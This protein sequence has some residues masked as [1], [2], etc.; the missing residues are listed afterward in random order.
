MTLAWTTAIEALSWIE[1]R[2]LNEDAA[3]SRATYQLGVDD[4]ETVRDAREVVYGVT[5][6]LNALDHVA[7]KALE[8]N[9][10]GNL[11]LG[12]RSFLRVFTYMV[13]YGGGLK[14]AYRF[15]EHCRQ[16]LGERKLS[17]V[18][19]AVELIPRLGIEFAGLDQDQALALTYF[20]PAW[21]VRY[22]KGAFGGEDAVKMLEPVKVPKYIRLNTLRD[23]EGT[24]RSLTS[25]GYALTKDP[26]LPYVYRLVEG[27]GI[28]QT[29]E[30]G[31]GEFLVQDK[32]SIL[33]GEVASPEPGELVLDVCGA[34]GIKTSHLAQLMGNEGRIISVDSSRRRLRS[35][36][37]LITR[38]GVKIAKPYHGDARSVEGLPPVE[39]DLVV[40]DP[41]CT[42]TGNLHSEPSARWRLGQGS[43]KRMAGIQRRILGSAA[44]SVAPGGRLI[45]CTCSVTVEENEGV[46]ARFLERNPGFRL[47]DASP[48]LGAEGLRGLG[49]AQRFY[50]HL[51]GCNGFFIAKMLRS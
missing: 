19:E 35:Y 50:P 47:V 37:T 3:L 40:V 29:S 4:R 30:H 2:R 46:V 42:G 38:L 12:V 24:V 6:H 39:A 11:S 23:A 33:A 1:L 9:N 15:D 7:E 34:P 48:R 43:I 5:S 25:Q 28:A 16:L 21:Y 31:R 26:D 20:H 18:D 14:D 51:H 44:S 8:P 27:D 41:P 36:E 49:E 13:H 17:G 32:A 22:L 10:L 45:Y